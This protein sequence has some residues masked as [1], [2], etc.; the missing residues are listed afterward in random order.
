MTQ[1]QSLTLWDFFVAAPG[2]GEA[3]AKVLFES[4]DV[5]RLRKRLP[6]LLPSH[7]WSAV[8]DAIGEKVKAALNTPISEVFEGAWAKY[9]EIL[10]Y[11]DE[12]KYGP[13]ET[14]LV[15]LKHYRITSVQKP[16]IELLFDNQKVGEIPFVVELTLEVDAG[17]STY[18]LGESGRSDLVPAPAPG[19]SNS[20]R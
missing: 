1:T 11:T 20:T 8:L 18:G 2:L 19:P 7:F 3:E 5:G 17:T 9:A 15:P 6:S 4:D 16:S 10:K 12:D 13:D 14:V